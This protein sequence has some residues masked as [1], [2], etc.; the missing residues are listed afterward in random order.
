MFLIVIMFTVIA[1]W[2]IIEF[3]GEFTQTYPLTFE[4]WRI[5]AAL[6]AVSIPLGFV[7]RQIPV[8]EDPDSYAG[9]GP[10][11]PKKKR[12]VLRLLLLV[13]S[14]VLVAIIYQLYWEVE[15]LKH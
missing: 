14:P 2:G 9:I 3:G 1:Q 5:T 7:M 10:K 6:G 12:N 8:L 11:K 4:E 15:E 13:L